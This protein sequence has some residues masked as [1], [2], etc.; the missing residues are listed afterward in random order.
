MGTAQDKSEGFSVDMQRRRVPQAEL[1]ML[2]RDNALIKRFVNVV[3]DEATRAGWR[4]QSADIDEAA[5]KR[6]VREQK[7]L[8]ISHT[9]RRAGRL[10]RKSGGCLIY[11]AAQ[12][13]G[14]P[15]LSEPLDLQKIE[16]VHGLVVLEK[17]EFSPSKWDTDITT[18]GTNYGRPSH[19]NLTPRLFGG[20]GYLS[21]VH[22]SRCLYIAGEE[23]SNE[24]R[25]ENSGC[26]ESV[27]Q[28]TYDAFRNRAIVDKAGAT[29]ATEL[30][31]D[32]L[33][34][35]ELTERSAEDT[36][37]N[38]LTRLS[39]MMQSKS[40]NRA[41]LLDTNDKYVPGS[42]GVSG[43]KDLDMNTM[44]QIGASTGIALTIMFGQPPSGLST[45]DKSGRETFNRLVGEYQQTTFAE[46]LEHLYKVVFAADKGPTD[47]H[48][49]SFDVEFLPL[50]VAS[51]TEQ[52]AL[53]K[54]YAE[55]DKINIE[56]GVYSPDRA[57]MRYT[58][59]FAANLPPEEEAIDMSE[60]TSLL[61]S[62]GEV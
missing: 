3:P 22:H 37:A 33:Y 56:L 47:G 35:H 5:R 21:D 58:G 6:L 45:D 10:G 9:F 30:K 54:T 55:V 24:D 50:A 62:L 60:L 28:H 48:V 25:I 46:P 31:V 34:V 38:L 17:G 51:P 26:D 49:P 43:F 29:L 2:Y 23:S 14:M 1:D 13:T 52:A 19:W 32:A 53:Q 27:I 7:R 44:Y 41:V 4:V 16:K 59:G 61:A 12:E 57:A 15:D 18:A 40:N 42:G 39:L 8:K 36:R 20:S 11:I